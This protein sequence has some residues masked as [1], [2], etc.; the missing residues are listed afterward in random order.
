MAVPTLVTALRGAELLKDSL[1]NKGT[2]FTR[3]ERRALELEALL[4][5]QE[6]TIERQVERCW[7]AFEAMGS[8]LERFAYLQGLRERNLTL[9]HRFLAEHIES[10]LPIVYTPTVGKAIQQ[11]SQSYRSP[12]HGVYLAAPDQE[13]LPELLRQAC[14]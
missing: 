5:W 9:F 7:L 1:L 14:E 4:P 11:F 8:D 13:R 10:A 2:A 3:E 12:S 6:E